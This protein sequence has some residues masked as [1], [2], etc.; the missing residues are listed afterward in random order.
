MYDINSI[1]SLIEALGG[2]TV[3]GNEFGLS[4]EAVSN[5]SARGNI[6]GGW[7]LLLYAK[8]RRKNLTVNPKVFNLSERDVEGLFAENDGHSRSKKQRNGRCSETAA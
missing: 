4:Q 3:V 5:W 7:H 8:A 2:P 6:A 1:E